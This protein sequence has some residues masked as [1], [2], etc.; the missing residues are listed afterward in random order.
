MRAIP[1]IADRQYGVF[2]SGQAAA[3]GWTS[4]GL[5][6]AVSIGRLIR[7]RRGLYACAVSDSA[8]E[9]ARRA[10]VRLSVGTSLSV[11][12]AVISHYAAAVL[13]G[14]PVYGTPLGC[15]TIAGCLSGDL[16][17]A[18]LHRAVLPGAHHSRHG[19]LKLTS[20]PRTVIDLARERDL[21]AG[22]VAADFALRDGQITDDELARCLQECEGWPGI[23]TARRV[24]ELADANSESPLESLSRLELL[25]RD[26]PPFRLQAKLFDRAGCYIRRVDFCWDAQRVVGEADGMAK[27]DRDPALIR[28]ERLSHER[29][30]D[31]GYRVVRWGWRDV[32]RFDAVE[33]RIRRALDRTPHR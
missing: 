4:H 30:E 10:A 27:Y 16:S 20:I 11:S 24:A 17:G 21:A 32:S 26:L 12:G 6:H 2:T 18:H 23:R 19:A 9:S 15:V 8:R 33:V 7:L 25:R 29:L 28:A 22:V 14:L 1:P 13:H 31:A 3:A 5:R